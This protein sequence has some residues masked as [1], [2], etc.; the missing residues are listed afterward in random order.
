[1]K[2]PG[3]STYNLLVMDY[4]IDANVVMSMLITG[5]AS[6]YTLAKHFRFYLPSY[7]LFELNEYKDVL[8]KQSRLQPSEVRDFARRLFPLLRIVPSLAIDPENHERAAM[9]TKSIDPKD[10]EYLALALQ[11]DAVFLSRDK[12]LISGIKKN[13]FRNAMMFDEF[14]RGL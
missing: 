9:L 10:Q 11:L 7:A 6:Y 8:F 14:L 12:P 4:L 2:L 5:K 13:S 3:R 1:M